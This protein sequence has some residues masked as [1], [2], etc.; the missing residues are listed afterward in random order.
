MFRHL[1]Q[2]DHMA[3]QDATM[4]DQ[5]LDQLS[6]RNK[7]HK[8]RVNLKNR[9]PRQLAHKLLTL[10]RGKT[11]RGKTFDH[12]SILRVFVNIR[13]QCIHERAQYIYEIF[14]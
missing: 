2:S 7:Q 4:L 14:L 11:L 9:D 12:E 13:F 1:D 3:K 8:I 10:T 6:T 5:F